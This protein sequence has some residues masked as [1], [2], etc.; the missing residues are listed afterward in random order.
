MTGRA[1]T[2]AAT[3]SIRR[4]TRSRDL[5]ARNAEDLST[6]PG[7]TSRTRA[8]SRSPATSSAR[9]IGRQPRHRRARRR[10]SM[11]AADEPLP[12]SRRADLR[13]RARATSRTSAA[14]T[15]AG[16]TTT[17]A[18]SCTFQKT[19]RIPPDFDRDVARAHA[20]SAGRQLSRLH[21]RQRQSERRLAART[22]RVWPQ[23]KFDYM[24]DASPTG[25]LLLDAG[26]PQDDVPRELEV[27]R[28]GRLPSAGRPPVGFEIFRR[29]AARENPD[30]DSAVAQAPRKTMNDSALA[31]SRDLGGGHAML[32]VIPHRLSERDFHLAKRRAVMPGGEEYIEAMFAAYG[33]RARV[34]THRDRRRSAPR[35][36]PEPAVDQPARARRRARSPSTGPTSTSS[37]CASAASANEIQRD[38][39]AQARGVLRIRPASASPTTPRS[40]NAIPTACKPSVNPWIDLSRG[41]NRE[42]VDAD[43]SIVG[44]ITDEVTQRG[45][46]R[47]WARLM[48]AS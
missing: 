25:E 2:S 33:P 22:S 31:V 44:H 14:S 16:R 35:R 10:R 1:S 11:P 13:S 34:R 12:A 21:L 41:R 27:R 32:D 23:R 4:S 36:F 40:S 29:N 20:R 43:G 42:R 8:R 15:T 46:L 24:I 39:R 48:S 37:R 5:R 7:S 3:G 18:R 17:P 47:E 30:V 26:R 38:A 19:T 6:R 28:D 45:Q 9:T